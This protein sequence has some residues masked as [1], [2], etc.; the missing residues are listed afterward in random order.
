MKTSG[1]ELVIVYTG[2]MSLFSSYSFKKIQFPQILLPLF[3]LT[4]SPIASYFVCTVEM[5]SI[6]FF[7]S[8][9]YLL[10]GIYFLRL[11]I[12]RT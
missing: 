9:S 4:R 12:R 2:G 1:L 7:K 10:S 5:D 11:R 3:L 8:S 6:P